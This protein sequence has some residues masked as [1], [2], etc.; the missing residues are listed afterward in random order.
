MKKMM[1]YAQL[2][3]FAEYESMLIC[4]MLMVI[5]IMLVDVCFRKSD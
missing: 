4:I 5:V 3:E 2:R 1:T